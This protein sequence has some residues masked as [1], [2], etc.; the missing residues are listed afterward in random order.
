MLKVK[1]K[2]NAI[3]AIEIIITMTLYYF[4]FVGVTAVTY[5]LD[6]VKTNHENI[7]FSAYF[8]DSK[9]EKVNKIE[10]FGRTNPVGIDNFL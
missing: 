2:L 7:D 5:A 8:L 9:G 10:N 4:I 1:R 3:I 6:I